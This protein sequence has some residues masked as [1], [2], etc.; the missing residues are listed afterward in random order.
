M[1]YTKEKPLVILCV[2]FIYACASVQKGKE[3]E[4]SKLNSIFIENDLVQ[5]ETYA[6]IKGSLPRFRALLSG[7]FV[8]YVPSKDT[9]SSEYVVWLTAD[10]QDSVIFYQIPV[11]EPSKI[12]YWL[13]NYQHLTSLPDKPLQ[14]NFFKLVEIDRDTILA[15]IYSAPSDFE[16]SVLDVIKDPKAIFDEFNWDSLKTEGATISYVR[17][18]PVKYVGTSNFFDYDDKETKFVAQFYQIT[19]DKI[20]IELMQ[21]DIGKNFLEI[22]NGNWLCKQGALRPEFFE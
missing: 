18:T 19:H 21:Y 5:E 11:G 12:G 1:I 2:V 6:E 8:Q 10:K 14:H 7:K 20:S 16:P 9:A 3:K 15:T 17:K 13:Y 22:G 4:Q